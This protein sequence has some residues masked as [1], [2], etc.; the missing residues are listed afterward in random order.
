MKTNFLFTWIALLF[1][2]FTSGQPPGKLVHGWEVSKERYD[3]ALI[4]AL[5]TE[6]GK[7]T[8]KQINSII[9]IRNGKLLI[10]E[11]FNGAERNQ[12]HNPRSVGKTFASAALGIAI[13]EGHIKNEYQQLG[14]FYNLREFQNYSGRKASVMLKHLLTMSSAFDANDSDPRS[15]GNEENMYPQSNWVKWALDLPM[16][17][18]REPG[19]KFTYFTGGVVVLGDIIHKSV[20]GGLESYAHEKLFKP[21]GIVNYRWQRTPQNVA[22]TA[23]GIQLIPLDFAKFGQLY[24]SRGK[25]N[26]Q[27]I[28]PEK[29]VDSSLARHYQANNDNGYGYLWWNKNYTVR[30]KAYNTSYCS[31]NGGNKI[32][33]FKDLATVIVVTASAYNQRY[34]HPQVDEMMI[35]YI[36][37]SIL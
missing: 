20:P 6:I 2:G 34:A 3:T 18:D 15:I 14:E 19:E 25:W 24:L 35:K 7:D 33:V 37:P 10:E 4:R 29:W 31:G 26:G 9:V 16:A 11:Y 27:Q 21:L 12:R 28:L 36:L 30:N 22:N 5:K 17:T 8:Y 13:K 1:C 32:F 23:G